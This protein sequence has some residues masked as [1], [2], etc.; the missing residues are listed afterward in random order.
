MTLHNHSNAA[1]ISVGVEDDRRPG[2]AE[3]GEAAAEQ[4]E[5]T[6]AL[7]RQVDSE[8]ERQLSQQG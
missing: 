5:E 4:R 8:W 2:T 1:A 3:P 6:V 7:G